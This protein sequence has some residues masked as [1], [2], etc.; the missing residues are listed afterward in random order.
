[1]SRRDQHDA[2]FAT[3]MAARN[4]ALF[5]SAYALTAS[6][7]AAEDLVQTVLTRTYASWGRVR[8]AEDP[9]AYVHRMLINRFLSDRRRRSSR[10]TPVEALPDAVGSTS[11]TSGA[12]DDRMALVAALATLPRL[13]RAVVVLRFWEDRSVADTASLLGL[14]Q[15]AVKNRTARALARLRTVL[16]A[17]VTADLDPDESHLAIDQRHPADRPDRPATRT[18]RGTLR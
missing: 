5:R 17:D 13:D 2:E 9:V 10:E 14:T 16:A 15:P 6:P 8:A 1:M 4:D 18:T 11:S 3:F 7:Q 12:S